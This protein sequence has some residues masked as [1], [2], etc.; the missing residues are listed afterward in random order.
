MSFLKNAMLNKEVHVRMGN[1]IPKEARA[2]VL[3]RFIGR[4]GDCDP[5]AIFAIHYEARHHIDR[6]ASLG[7]H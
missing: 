2:V 5:Q 7:D 3:L 1:G 6:G 4:S